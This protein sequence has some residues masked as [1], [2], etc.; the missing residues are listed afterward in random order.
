MEKTVFHIDRDAPEPLYYQLKQVFR[1]QICNGILKPGDAIPPERELVNRYDVSRMTVRLAIQELVQEGLIVKYQGKGTFVAQP[2][3]KRS[4]SELRSFSEDMSA[5][6]LH[7]G[8]RLMDLR[9]E[10]ASEQVCE[11][12]NIA[13]GTK[14]TIVERVRTVDNEE[15]LSLSRSFLHL[16]EEVVLTK[17]DFQAEASLWALLSRKGIDITDAEETVQAIGANSVQAKL[18]KIAKGT[19]LLMMDGISY[20]ADGSPVESYCNI[21]RADRFKYF[22]RSERKHM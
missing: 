9:E 15:P 11:A 19:P 12:L 1:T 21:H 4:L 16:P 17:E 20:T 5:S 6:G 3:I 2:K 13:P 18:F 7:P 14:I 10:N 8:S 22:V